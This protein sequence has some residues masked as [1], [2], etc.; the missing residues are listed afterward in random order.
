MPTCTASCTSCQLA[1]AART[2]FI[3][4]SPSG[5]S[6]A[7]PASSSASR[8]MSDLGERQAV[9]VGGQREPWQHATLPAA[10][11]RS[12]RCRG[13]GRPCRRS[14]R[15]HR[16]RRSCR[17]SRDRRSPGTRCDGAG[18]PRS[19]A[20]HRGRCAR[21][22]RRS[23]TSSSPARASN[24]PAASSSST[25][26]WVATRCTPARAAGA[27]STTATTATDGAHSSAARCTR[28]IR[29][30]RLPPGARVHYNPRA[31]RYSRLRRCSWAGSVGAAGSGMM[32][33]ST[34]SQP[35]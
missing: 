9:E 8:C 19:A 5:I 3:A 24:P 25:V 30:A 27:G 22:C 34:T 29:P 33:C 31:R 32:S 15:R 10:T 16:S 13:A 21:R 12:P 26:A 1:R 6:S 20:P 11:T 7:L 18:C 2:T 23:R 4:P 35:A 17:R 14:C 28:P